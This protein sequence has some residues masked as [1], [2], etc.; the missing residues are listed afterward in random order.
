MEE[1]EGIILRKLER[2]Q[3]LGGDGLNSQV[4]LKGQMRS[5]ADSGG[6]EE[7]KIFCVPD[8]CPVPT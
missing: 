3:R 4:E 5:D 2:Q 1:Y 6:K 7:A 8:G